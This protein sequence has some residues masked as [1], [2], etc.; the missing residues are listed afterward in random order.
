MAKSHPKA[1]GEYESNGVRCTLGPP[2][3][4]AGKSREGQSG[5]EFG[6]N[7]AP[8]NHPQSMGNGSIPTKFFDDSMGHTPARSES[9]A[10]ASSPIGITKRNVGERRFKN[11]G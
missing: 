5:G 2:F 8:F 9:S 7:K 3:D 6:A 10:G 4:K 11:P 1:P